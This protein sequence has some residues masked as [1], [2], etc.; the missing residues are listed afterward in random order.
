MEQKRFGS[1]HSGN[2]GRK[3][4]GGIECRKQNGGII[5]FERIRRVKQNHSVLR[6]DDV[7]GNAKL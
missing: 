7:G 2:L 1:D 5:G 6:N 3:Q 4:N